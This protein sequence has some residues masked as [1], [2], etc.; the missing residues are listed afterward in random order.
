MPERGWVRFPC[1]GRTEG[2]FTPPLGESVVKCNTGQ[3]KH[4]QDFLKYSRRVSI[5]PHSGAQSA[6][7]LSHAASAPGGGRWENRTLC[8]IMCFVV[9]FYIFLQFISSSQ[10]YTKRS[11]ATHHFV[12]RRKVVQLHVTVSSIESPRLHMFR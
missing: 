12:M 7:A 8:F 9:F 2:T 10:F 11:I 6:G 3:L 1:E 5:R 4:W